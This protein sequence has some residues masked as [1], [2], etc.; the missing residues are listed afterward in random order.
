M[1]G[2]CSGSGFEVSGAASRCAFGCAFE[3]SVV[4]HL[5]PRTAAPDALICR[6]PLSHNVASFGCGE[7]VFCRVVGESVRGGK[8]S[9]ELNGVR[10]D[11]VKGGAGGG[12]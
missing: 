7:G 6:K 11:G 2:A 1:R 9:S 8:C 10:V 4:E 12:V 5:P 3:C